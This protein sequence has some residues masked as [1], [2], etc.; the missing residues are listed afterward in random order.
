MLEG[1]PIQTAMQ[2]EH[3]V[4]RVTFVPE[5]WAEYWRPVPSMPRVVVVVV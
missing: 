2:I 4:P 3:H 1:L 5:K